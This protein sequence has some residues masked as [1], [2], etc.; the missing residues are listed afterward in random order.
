MK[1]TKKRKRRLHDFS[2]DVIR[3]TVQLTVVWYVMAG[4]LHVLAAYTPDYFLTLRF[5]DDALE[6]APVLLAVGIAGALIA[7]LV[8]SRQNGGDA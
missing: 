8:L 7:D 5:R 4:L 6:T 2:R 3:G 1:P